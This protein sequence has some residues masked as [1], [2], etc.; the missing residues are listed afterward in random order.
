MSLLGSWNLGLCLGL[1]TW[2]LRIIHILLLILRTPL[3]ILG[4]LAR[5]CFDLLVGNEPFLL[6]N[7]DIPYEG[8]AFTFFGH[9][10]PFTRFVTTSI[11]TT[12]T[13]RSDARQPSRMN[14]FFSAQADVPY[15]LVHG[16][17]DTLNDCAM[18]TWCRCIM[19]AVFMPH[20]PRDNPTIVVERIADKLHYSHES[21]TF[22]VR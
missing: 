5:L 15:V 20:P 8:Y 6:F 2:P 13:I 21:Q 18:S 9:L 10:L 19:E 3:A 7:S 16:G 14:M 1:G 11:N 12:V 22:V 17:F 4:C